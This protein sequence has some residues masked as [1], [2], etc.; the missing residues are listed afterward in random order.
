MPSRE[1]G[2]GSIWE[3]KNPQTENFKS[4]SDLPP[5]S[6]PEE[7]SLSPEFL[8]LLEKIN[9]ENGLGLG[10]MKGDDQLAELLAGLE[11]KQQDSLTRKLTENLKIREQEE[12]IDAA[13]EEFC[14]KL[15][16]PEEYLKVLGQLEDEH[17]RKVYRKAM[18][19]NLAE[20]I[21]QEGPR[22]S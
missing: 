4:E 8:E 3:S 13:F 18:L 7:F 20:E 9:Q 2:A 12:E 17:Q 1:Q 6:A 11:Q 14:G 16:V 22:W 10:P 19:R 5:G 21:K 15:G